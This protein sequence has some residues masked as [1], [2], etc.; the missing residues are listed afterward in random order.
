M[1]ACPHLHAEPP[2]FGGKIDRAIWS[3]TLTSTSMDDPT[4]MGEITFE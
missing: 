4:V 1:S 2:Q 3:S